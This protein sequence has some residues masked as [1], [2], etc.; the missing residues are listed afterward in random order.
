MM[1][2][3]IL[4]PVAVLFVG[5]AFAQDCSPPYRTGACA[6]CPGLGFCIGRATYTGGPY[7]DSLSLSWDTFLSA[8]CAAGSTCSPAVPPNDKTCPP[9][10]GENACN[11]QTVTLKGACKGVPYTV[12]HVT[13]CDLAS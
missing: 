5:S 4:A 10:P 9:T 7:F 11:Q 12:I 8:T 3:G 13:C 1:R 2:F 6:E